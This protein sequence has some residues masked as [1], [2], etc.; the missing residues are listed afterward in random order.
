MIRV[1]PLA[2]LA[3]AVVGLVASGA[4]AQLPVAP[5][6]REVRP[7][8]TRDPA[9]KAEAPA[10]AEDPAAV[11]DRIIKNSKD[12]GD[13]LENKDAGADTRTKQDKILSDIDALINRQ[14]DPPPPKP[15]DKNDKND[16]NDM[17]KDPMT[18]KDPMMKDMPP[19]KGDTPMDKKGTGMG[20]D[21]GMPM[22]GMNDPPPMPM[23][24]NGRRPRMGDPMAG[25]KKDP[26]DQQPDPTKS[27]N[28]KAPG[29]QKDPKDPSGSMGGNPGG[30]VAP[31]ALVPQD[32]DVS[33]D[34]WGHLPDKLRRQM[35]QY[36]K[37]DVMPKYA[38][39]LRLYYSSLAEPGAPVSPKK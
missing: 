35:T 31:K 36:Y 13:R 34:V 38:E 15:D 1:T 8:G 4:R 3:A 9:P 28:K 19:P 12:V 2:L 23:G 17:P 39:L 25:D 11:V 29:G 5:P 27:D 10:R 37:E 26:G 22:A 20:K 32:E 16:K 18:G 6:P 24:G 7:D 21:D 14:E 33:K 30:K